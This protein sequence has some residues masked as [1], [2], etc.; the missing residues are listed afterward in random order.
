MTMARASV[1]AGARPGRLAYVALFAVALPLLLVLWAQRLDRW[2]PTV[3]IASVTIGTLI[4]VAGAGLMLHAM[5]LLWWEGGGLPASPY[6]PE[7]LVTRGPYLVFTHPIYVGAIATCLGL[8]IAAGSAGGV[9]VVTP[10]LAASAAAWVWGFERDLTRRLFGRVAAPVLSLPERS[11][12]RP[13]AIQRA[14]VYAIVFVPWVLLYVA[15]ELLAMPPDARSTFMWWE[16]MLPVWPAGSIVSAFLVIFVLAVPLIARRRRDLREFA[17]EALWAM[18]VVFAF[19][20]LL[21][22]AAAYH[23][24]WAFIAARAWSACWPRIRVAVLTVV[25]AAVTICLLAALCATADV[26][27]ACMA[28]LVVHRRRWIARRFLDGAERIANSWNEWSLGPAR[29]LSHGIYAGVGAGLGVGVAVAIVGMEQL[30]WV[31]AL[32]AAAILGAGLWAQLVEGSP[33]LLRPFGYFGAVAA[34]LLVLTIAAL[35]GAHLWAT[36][37][38]FCIGSTITY[39]AGRMRCLVQGCCHGSPAP[40][41]IGIIYR[42]PRSRVTRLSA[43]AGVPVHATPLYSALW[44]L[45]VGAVLVRLWSLAAPLPF[46]VGLYFI[47]TGLGRFVEEHYR[48]EPQTLV[49][50][51]L[52]LYQWLAIGCVALGAA[53]TS[54]TG[55]SA[56]GFVGIDPLA[57][58]VLVTVMLVAYAAYG[59]EFPNSNR[60][61][62]RLT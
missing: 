46:I 53:I 55:P 30:W 27:V 41:D 50:S 40:A 51:G 61:F 7:R 22:F 33:Q 49:V 32:T 19:D 45:L 17:L 31:V 62:S 58:P 59:L 2:I 26:I 44:M 9:W 20:L 56:A 10:V 48:G 5:A 6:P 47:L 34:V 12:A 52:R 38:A 3:P 54:L 36:T 14:A 23:L 29:L 60:R 57:I 16:R 43:L 28:Y 42:E 25:A 35:A 37:G 15:V 39:A 21:P 8:S 4:A 24:V 1:S 11:D 13:S 18:A